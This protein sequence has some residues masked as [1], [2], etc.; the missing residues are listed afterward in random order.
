MTVR[1]LPERALAALCLSGCTLLFPF[2]EPSSAPPAED[3][4]PHDAALD[5]PTDAALDAFDPGPCPERPI[6]M[7]THDDCRYVCCAE[8]CGAPGNEC[9]IEPEEIPRLPD[10][11]P[12]IDAGWRLDP[13]AGCDL[14]DPLNC[15]GCG[16]ACHPGRPF[17]C[18]EGC[19]REECG[20]LPNDCS[21]E[22][23]PPLE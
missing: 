4:G 17:C 7:R 10:A 9:S 5:A 12:P 20:S 23:G 18:A 6:E 19:C 3:A 1:T 15:L 2:S 16:V 8:E 13:D 22:P 21:I 14:T 11:G